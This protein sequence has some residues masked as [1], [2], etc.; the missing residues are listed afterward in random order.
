LHLDLHI[1]TTCSDG[2]MAPEQVVMQA[3]KAGLHAIAITDHDTTSGLARAREEAA[4]Q[5]VRF[6]AGTELSVSFQGAEM[7][8]LGYGIAPENPAIGAIT[9]RLGR[10]RHERV[11]AIVDRLT[12]LGVGI[13]VADVATPVGN[14]SIGRPHVAEALVKLGAVRHVQEAFSRFLADGGPAWIPSRGPDVADAIA[15]I[16]DAGGLSVWA[17]PSMDDATRFPKLRAL[18][19]DGV[20]VL[21]PGL[22]P[23]T[24]SALEHAARDAGLVSSGGSDWHGGSPPLGSWYV[25]HRHVGALLE[26]L[27][28][29][30]D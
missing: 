14:A 8:L 22:Q 6:I 23:V 24:S 1:H 17:H 26:R 5:G 25:T 3:R 2:Q 9:E 20:E 13:T 18:G 12:A 28:I 7:H 11:G 29:S 4:R 19:L 10:L 16:H 21:R 30:P 27:G 15:A